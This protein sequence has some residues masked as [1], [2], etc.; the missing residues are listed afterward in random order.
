[1]VPSGIFAASPADDWEPAI[2]RVAGDMATPIGCDADPVPI[3]AR[4]QPMASIAPRSAL[5]T[6]FTTP[7]DENAL[8]ESFPM[9][10]PQSPASPPATVLNPP[11]LV[12]PLSIEKYP[13]VAA[14]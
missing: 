6:A 3:A 4:S 11:R 5:D 7:E 8:N 1:M 2:D 10:V 13:G 12:T 9:A 14:E